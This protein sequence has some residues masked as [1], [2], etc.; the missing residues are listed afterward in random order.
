MFT[1]FCAEIGLSLRA[2][3]PILTI[4]NLEY[5][6]IIQGQQMKA[7]L[8]EYFYNI[9]YIIIKHLSETIGSKISLQMS[10]QMSQKCN[11]LCFYYMCVILCCKCS[12]PPN[13][14]CQMFL[15]RRSPHP[16]KN[17]KS[18]ATNTASADF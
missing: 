1:N 9:Q 18:A 16:T 13:Y 5:L 4:W 3:G 17:V 8:G 12:Q 10:L 6:E 2:P 14:H 15:K 11:K 7:L